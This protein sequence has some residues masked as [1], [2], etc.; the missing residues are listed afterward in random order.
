MIEFYIFLIVSIIISAIGGPYFGY[1]LALSMAP[2]EK[3]IDIPEIATRKL[4]G[5]VNHQPQNTS[6]LSISYLT[7]GPTF[8]Q[9]GYGCYPGSQSGGDPFTPN[10][11]VLFYDGK[12]GMVELEIPKHLITK[13]PAIDEVSH[14]DWS[15]P[16]KE[17]PFQIIR[18][19]SSYTTIRIDVPS[20]YTEISVLGSDE[21]SSSP[22]LNKL[23]GWIF[24]LTVSLWFLC[25]ILY[26]LS[27]TLPQIIRE[28][29]GK[30][31]KYK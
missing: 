6:E 18:E 2:I 27:K 29:F 11:L 8:Y 10:C 31:A 9:F 17:I 1:M 12:P 7:T 22:F 13:F 16:D 15:L 28:K 3:D 30:F 24:I 20:N 14:G 19:D 4:V 23:I 21:G 26:V 5:Q 25:L